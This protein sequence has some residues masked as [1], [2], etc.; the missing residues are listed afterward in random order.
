MT[1]GPTE[2]W[3]RRLSPQLGP[4]PRRVL[5][6]LF[7]PGQEM[8]ADGESRAGGV[9]ERILALSEEEVAA[10]LEATLASFGSRHRDLETIFE[11]HFDLVAHRLGHHNHLTEERRLLMGAY[12][13]NEYSVEGAALFNPSIVLHPDQSQMGFGEARI[14][15]SLRAVGEGHLSCIEFRTGIVDAGSQIRID[16]PGTVLVPGRARPAVYERALFRGKLAELG[17]RGESAAFVLDALPERFTRLELELALAELGDQILT[18]T[19]APET[20]DHIRRVAASNYDTV[21]PEDSALG[22]RVLWPK[23]PTESHGMEDA[24]FVR[25]VDDDGSVTYYATYTAFDGV[26]VSPQLLETT[27]FRTFR[28]TQMTGPAARNKGM[29]LFP[30][31]IDGRYV[32]LSRWDRENNAIVTS[33]DC[34]AWGGP[35]TLQSPEQPWELLQIGNCGSP[36]ETADGWLVLT[37]GVGPMRVYSIGAL[38][39][40]LDDPTRV[41]ARLPEPVMVPDAS[42]RE[43]YVPNV[44]YSCGA[45][46]HADT[47][48]LP[49]GIGDAA[50]GVAVIRLSDL[51][52][53]LHAATA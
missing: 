31:R 49:Y 30:R 20:I 13:T 9:I 38:L 24:R 4:D 7:V 46:L 27:D 16:D 39:L 45:L 5:A 53:R 43:G 17:E 2:A 28:I 33:D 3:V 6:R 11:E 8:L 37:H 52:G 47:V 23:G 34:R 18:R 29:A 41:V 12:F 15:L 21:F 22:E 42:E 1:A 50:I 19:N 35:V 10:T 51:L 32:A 36:L 48:V 25:F 44:L 14:V 26:H 40:D